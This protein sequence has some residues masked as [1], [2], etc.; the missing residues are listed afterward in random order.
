MSDFSSSSFEDSDG[1]DNTAVHIQIVNGS[2]SD[3]DEPAE[4]SEPDQPQESPPSPQTTPQTVDVWDDSLVDQVQS[5]DRTQLGVGDPKL[6][7]LR[8]QHETKP[9]IS[10]IAPSNP[11]IRAVQTSFE[12]IK[13]PDRRLTPS[14]QEEKRDFAA[15]NQIT[16]APAVV[17][18]PPPSPNTPTT[19]PISPPSPKKATGSVDAINDWSLVHKKYIARTLINIDLT[20]IKTV[21]DIEEAV[22]RLQPDSTPYEGLVILPPIVL[23][24]HDDNH[25]NLQQ[26]SQNPH[27]DEDK[28]TETK[29]N[30]KSKSKSTS[31]VTNNAPA[32]AAAAAAVL[33]DNKQKEDEAAKKA[34]EIEAKKKREEEALRKKEEEKKKKD[35][36]KK[37]AEEETKRKKEEEKK[38]KDDEKKAKEDAKKAK[39][40][41]KKAKEDAKKAAEEEAKKKKQLEKEKKEQEKLAKKNK[42]KNGAAVVVAGSNGADGE[43]D[44]SVSNKPDDEVSTVAEPSISRQ[45]MSETSRIDS[46]MSGQITPCPINYNDPNLEQPIT[47]EQATMILQSQNHGKVTSKF[48]KANVFGTSGFKKPDHATCYFFQKLWDTDFDQNNRG[49]VLLLNAFYMYMNDLVITPNF[50]AD[51]ANKDHKRPEKCAVPELTGPHWASTLRSPNPEAPWE[52]LQGLPVR[53]TILRPLEHELKPSILPLYLAVYLLEGSANGDFKN[54][55]IALLRQFFLRDNS[56]SGMSYLEL[57]VPLGYVIYSLIMSNTTVHAEPFYRM[58]YKCN[59]KKDFELWIPFEDYTLNGFLLAITEYC[60]MLPL[61]FWFRHLIQ[62]YDYPTLVCAVRQRLLSNIKTEFD[63]IDTEYCK[64]GYAS[65]VHEVLND[66]YL[67]QDLKVVFAEQKKSKHLLTPLEA[68]MHMNQQARGPGRNSISYTAPSPTSNNTD[69][70]APKM[71]KIGPNI[72]VGKT[73]AQVNTP[74]APASPTAGDDNSQASPESSPRGKAPPPPRTNA[75]KMM[76]DI[77]RERSLSSV[78]PRNNSSSDAKEENGEN[79]DANGDKNE[80]EEEKDDKNDE[81][82]ENDQSDENKKSSTTAAIVDQEKTNDSDDSA[83]QQI[84]FVDEATPTDQDDVN[85]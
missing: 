36:E 10:P 85:Q 2:D 17:S 33:D 77:Q 6:F 18:P 5:R 65:Y 16:V 31:D 22:S 54:V 37:A 58:F 80:H 61:T 76:A 74:E 1:E 55:I 82:D 67:A 44:V 60:F 24:E 35:D 75:M 7:K 39:D 53:Y 32:A 48:H 14:K 49:H 45:S 73:Q 72:I 79:D 28:S 78:T 15:Q 21:D 70:T 52:E 69:E 4:K 26:N 40:D 50:N 38:K 43:R 46:T 84:N 23:L 34:A 19:Q 42:G 47:F 12:H 41:E 66:N 29:E 63:R 3:S 9:Q 59:L 20:N 68:Q 56:P 25:Q 30:S 62:Q 57:F 81:K 51:P 71:G 83:E 11:V 13:Q 8:Q 64:G 27:D